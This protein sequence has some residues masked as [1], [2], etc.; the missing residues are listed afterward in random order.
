MR[1][2]SI[3]INRWRNL[4]SVH[5]ELPADAPL[6]CLVGEN[7]T[8]KSNV[9]ELI[10]AAGFR[11]GLSPGIQLKRG[12]PLDEPH[13]FSIRLQLPSGFVLPSEFEQQLSAYAQADEWD[14]SLLLHHANQ[15]GTEATNMPTAGGIE[16]LN[17]ARAIGQIVQGA[18]Q[19]QQEVNLLYLDAERSFPALSLQDQEI[20]ALAR[21]NP[22][23]PDY[24]RQQAATLTQNMYSEW[25]KLMLAQQIRTATE[26]HERAMA[27]KRAHKRVPAP[28]D[29][30]ATFRTAVL[31]VLPYL[32]FVRLDQDERTLI[33]NSAGEDL[34]YE[35]LSG[36]E[37][38]ITF[39]IG[40]IERFQLRRG[41]VLL[42]EPELHLNSE[43]LRTWL[44]YLRSTIDEGQVW[45][46]THSL[47]AV[48]TAG[49]DASFILERS[50]DRRVR[51][52]APLS[53]RPALTSLAGALGSPSFSLGR[54]RFL[55]IEGE[56]LGRERERMAQVLDADTSTKF[57]E[58]GGCREVIR[59]LATLK[60]LAVE[61]EEL[62]V[63]GI[64]DR[65]SRNDKQ[66]QELEAKTG[67]HVLPCHEIE[68][69]FLQP[70]AIG[71]L[72]E[73]A[74]RSSDGAEGLIQA[75][76]DLYAGRWILKRASTEKGWADVDPGIR[77]QAQTLMWS[78]IEPDIQAQT[79]V[80]T[81]L[82]TF[83]AE[84]ERGRMRQALQEAAR[85][86][87][88]LRGKP[89]ELWKRCL[90][91]EVLRTLA[92]ELSLRNAEALENRVVALWTSGELNR[93]AEVSLTKAY[94]EG[95]E[96]LP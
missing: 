25:M 10:A 34:R 33:F 66:V 75:Q 60:E 16:D 4:E 85:E 50:N 96:V 80:W 42:D 15:A 43:L 52:A 31:A 78:D 44:S 73:Q 37:R 90:G 18:L 64:V 1:I 89:S 74:G 47:E 77:Q 93:P 9:L 61:A 67:A 3:T 30:L 71:R 86:Y 92:G 94:I 49:L 27:A 65:D 84:A 72:L 56:R 12:N 69:F 38:E 7:G 57:L 17:T 95:I 11:L 53:E 23:V 8:G 48:E 32:K 91:K 79:K 55:V 63:G 62:R 29:E 35:S 22:R 36:G 21:Q 70:A 6:I 88:K 58:A 39:L 20:W 54:S 41:L 26:Y 83:E 45:I 81:D 40:Q 28:E 51:T 19:Q 76:S 5:L 14:M 87:K 2:D 24:V 68:N 82:G 13:D 59:K 46:A